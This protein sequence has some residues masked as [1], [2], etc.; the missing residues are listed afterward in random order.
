MTLGW[1]HLELPVPPRSLEMLLLGD[2]GPC[3]LADV[4]ELPT[5]TDI[6]LAHLRLQELCLPGKWHWV[7]PGDPLTLP[8]GWTHPSAE[9]PSHGIQVR[10]QM[11]SGS[12]P[13]RG[14]AGWST[15][16]EQGTRGLFGV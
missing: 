8:G 7:D 4:A 11:R 6:Q 1:P 12:R 14:H 16:G 13:W 2:R 3:V 15:S 5:L 9:T 10:W